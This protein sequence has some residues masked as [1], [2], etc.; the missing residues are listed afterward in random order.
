MNISGC[1]ATDCQNSMHGKACAARA[2]TVKEEAGNTPRVTAN[3]KPA[4]DWA[5]ISDEARALRLQGAEANDGRNIGRSHAGEE[6]EDGD[7]LFH[8][9]G[10]HE[11]HDD[12]DDHGGEGRQ[13]VGKGELS[14]DEQRKVRELQQRDQRVRAHEQAHVAA[15]GRIAVSAPSYEYETGPDGRQYAV[16]GSVNYNVPAAQSAQEELLLAQQL[17][18]MAL[19]PMDPS[20]KDRAA[21]ADASTKEAR[22]NREIREEKVEEQEAR[23]AEQAEAGEESGS[24]VSVPGSERQDRVAIEADGTEQA[25]EMITR[26]VVT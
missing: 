18:R 5:I 22:A 26:L 16:G 13:S 15:S 24:A 2:I 12:D 20:P 11:H 17:R 1:R 8:E 14:Q 21:A 25:A 4:V 7:D 3:S 10:A 19:A 23:R 6:L 9:E